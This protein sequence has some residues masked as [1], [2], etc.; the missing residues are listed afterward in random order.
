VANQL[1]AEC[2]LEPSRNKTVAITCVP[3]DAH[4]LGAELLARYL[5]CRGWNQLFLGA[6]MP[7]P[8]LIG[9]LTATQPFAIVVSV[10]MTAFL[11]AFVELADKLRAALPATL[12]LAGGPA[13]IEPVLARLCDGVPPTFAQAHAL[14]EQGRRHA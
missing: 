5:E 9:T 12:L 13:R 2:R 1:F 14:L 11:P 3:G 8:D 10:R 7:Q 6:S 4:V